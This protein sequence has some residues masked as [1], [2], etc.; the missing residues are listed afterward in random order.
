MNPDVKRRKRDAAKKR[1]AKKTRAA[2]THRSRFDKARQKAAQQP[3]VREEDPREERTAEGGAGAP[4][5]DL[6]EIVRDAC[7]QVAA[8]RVRRGSGGSDGDAPA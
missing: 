8:E 3:P 4:T 7:R 2:A 5:V 1:K 6:T